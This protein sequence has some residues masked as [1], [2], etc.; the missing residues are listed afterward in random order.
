M[1][2]KCHRTELYSCS[3]ICLSGQAL[4]W[5]IVVPFADITKEG[6][7]WRARYPDQVGGDNLEIQRDKLPGSPGWD[8]AIDQGFGRCPDGHRDTQ[9]GCRW[10]RRKVTR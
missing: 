5:S 6:R 10:Y 1:L 4:A 9:D 7:L 3:H 2:T 8:N